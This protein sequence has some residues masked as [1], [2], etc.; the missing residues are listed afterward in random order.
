MPALTSA[1]SPPPPV[2]AYNGTQPTVPLASTTP[3]TRAPASYSSPNTSGHPWTSGENVRDRERGIKKEE[4]LPKPSERRSDRVTPAPL[5]LVSKPK[6]EPTE[7]EKP[8]SALL[9]SSAQSQPTPLPTNAPPTLGA[10]PLSAPPSRSYSPSVPVQPPN[11]PRTGFSGPSAN[12]G[13][14]PPTGPRAGL[15]PTG[16]R[17]QVEREGERK[18]AERMWARERGASVESTWSI[19]GTVPPSQPQPSKVSSRESLRDASRD[20]PRNEFGGAGH[21]HP[22]RMKEIESAAKVAEDKDTLSQVSEQSIINK[23]PKEASGFPPL[24]P[25][26]RG[27]SIASSRPGSSSSNQGFRGHSVGPTPTFPPAG[28]ASS[29]TTPAP[30]GPVNTLPKQPPTGPKNYSARRNAS[31]VPRGRGGFR[32]G[33]VGQPNVKRENGDEENTMSG[34]RGRGSRAMDRGRWQVGSRGGMN[35]ERGRSREA[36]S[37]IELPD[38]KTR[39]CVVREKDDGNSKP[40]VEMVDA[41]K[42]P[43]KIPSPP[44][45]RQ[46]DSPQLPPSV[47]PEDKMDEDEVEEEEDVLTQQDVIA[48]IADLDRDVELLEGKLSDLADR[49]TDHLSAMEKEERDQE[50]QAAAKS[51]SPVEEAVDDL[52]LIKEERVVIFTP[53]MSPTSPAPLNSVTSGSPATPSSPSEAGSVETES[54]E[55]YIARKNTPPGLP[56]LQ[57]GPPTKPSDMGFFQDSTTE[58]ESIKD[59]IIAEISSHKKEVHVKGTSLKRKYKELYSEWT[60]KCHDLDRESTRKKKGVSEPTETGVSPTLTVTPVP[61]P[62]TRR[63]GGNV[64]VGDVVRSEAEMEQVMRDLMEQDEAADAKAKLDGPKE[65]EVPDMILDDKEKLL[66]RDTNRLLRSNNEILRAYRYEI[67]ADNFTPEEQAK[68][69]EL[70][71][72]FPKQWHKIAAG[73]EER[74]FKACIQHY[75]MT[76]KQVNYKDLLNKGKRTRRK[77]GRAAAPAKTRQSALLADLGKGK[78]AGG[79]NGEDDDGDA[80]DVTPAPITERGRPKRA[81]APTFGQDASNNNNNNAKDDNE[82]QGTGRR[83][84]N[85][86][87]KGED[88]GQEKEK[89]AGTKRTRGGN[90]GGRERGNKRVRT[91]ATAAATPTPSIPSTPLP[92]QTLAPIQEKKPIKIKEDLGQRESD[93]VSALAGLSGGTE[94]IAPA[95]PNIVMCTPE[96]QPLPQPRTAASTPKKEKDKGDR[97]A[98][99]AT[100]SYWSVPEQ[101]DFPHLLASFGTNWGLI[102]QRLASKTTV[103]VWNFVPFF[104][105]NV[106]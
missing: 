80:E 2:P 101:N 37:D 23:D 74:D 57:G 62:V 42:L 100:S 47:K 66:F 81:A 88:D 59:F 34:Y 95:P 17:R 4:T 15:P 29:T 6:R 89:V 18:D 24:Q 13:A 63:R 12:V 41:P 69:C 79:G 73:M 83:G 10:T 20:P 1:T 38:A 60:Q 75:Y 78:G 106:N 53:A 27:S 104:I 105:L 45:K 32:G 31:Y 97:S 16:P 82:N 87:S 28:P 98:G 14:T 5:S 9:P 43:E 71:V 25:P 35:G 72:Q 50:A 36:P 93:A 86:E 85:K 21:V 94:N 26:Q 102:S 84:G 52:K 99:A 44:E 22:D 67:P 56:Y 68:F 61:E 30:S 70:Y 54:D 64:P 39:E 103:M 77:R 76:K 49:K 40:D 46:Q 48:K 58:H 19:G 8:F 7:D 90:N 11:G 33:F 96:S 91:P 65:A 51:K 3:P 92:Q 55:E